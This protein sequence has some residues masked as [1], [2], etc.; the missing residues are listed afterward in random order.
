MSAVAAL[1]PEDPALVNKVIQ[2]ILDDH[3]AHGVITAEM[4]ER[5]PGAQ[6]W[7]LASDFKKTVRDTCERA[8]YLE[9]TNLLESPR[10]WSREVLKLEGAKGCHENMEYSLGKN[11][12]P[13]LP[14]R[15][16][17]R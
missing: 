2:N 6:A 12:N 17:L 4:L 10:F 8:R 1:L 16:W 9:P 7:Q 14:W 3:R 15:P 5:I 13:F 11:V